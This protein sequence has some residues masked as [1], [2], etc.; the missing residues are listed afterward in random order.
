MMS[1]AK[2]RPVT[3]PKRP[4]VSCTAAAS[5]RVNQV[6]HNKPKPNGADLRVGADARRVVVRRTRD[7]ARSKGT[8]IA[9][10]PEVMA[11]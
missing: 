2:P 10:P 9:E 1:E 4:A 6:V 11:S 7:E 3:S 5:G 8:E